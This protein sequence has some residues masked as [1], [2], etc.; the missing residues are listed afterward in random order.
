MRIPLKKFGLQS[1]LGKD[2]IKC[3]QG[4]KGE[5]GYKKGPP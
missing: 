2:W 1:K 5:E 4:G 3:T